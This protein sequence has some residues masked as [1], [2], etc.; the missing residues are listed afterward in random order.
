M[1]P[2]LSPIQSS[3][4]ARRGARRRL[5]RL[6]F[7][8]VDG[9]AGRE[10]GAAR[11]AAAFDAVLLQP[12]IM[13]DV[14]ERDLGTALLGRR[15]GLPFGIAPMGMC[16]L[17]HP[18]AD[19]LLAEA[20]AR[21][22][23]PVCTS[24][25]ASTRLEEIA[26]W[27]GPRAWFQLYFGADAEASLAMVD[28]ARLAGY[29]TLVLTVDVPQVARRLRDLRNG[30]GLPFRMTPR[31][32]WDFAAHPR[33]S[34]A[35]LAAGVP[36]P[37]NFGDG[38]GAARF[39][40]A[41]SRAGAD[42]AFLARLREAWPGKLVVKGV[43]APEDARRVRS[44]GADAVYVST[45]GG[46]QLDAAPAAITLLPEIRAALG[47]DFPI[48]FDSGLRSGEDVVRALALGADFVMLGRPVLFALGADG[49]RGLDSLLAGF[50]ED[51]STAMAQLG[52]RA[53]S[54]IGPHSL[55]GPAPAAARGA[56]GDRA[57]LQI[58]GTT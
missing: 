38:S 22:D 35:T 54:G 30:F 52:V 4:D 5:P 16:N 13:A 55:H 3:E 50:R 58:A 48:L 10:R 31:A 51:I 23:M 12:R 41:A 6:V 43:T 7:D 39:D 14:A 26:G 17:V 28:R 20:A 25:A 47:P 44:H 45:H 8:F 32:A 42:W 46:R 15:Y 56:G 9:A 34:L 33:W 24:A 49:A 21:F 27:A 2:R 18:G 36:R 11:N 53:V 57:A 40:R 37:R 19:R 29:E 1:A